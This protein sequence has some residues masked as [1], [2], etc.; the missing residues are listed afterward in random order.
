MYQRNDP[1]IYDASS[2]VL[3]A[4]AECVY[5]EDRFACGVVGACV[6]AGVEVPY[7]LIVPPG[8]EWGLGQVLA[9]LRGKEALGPTLGSVGVAVI[10]SSSRTARC[11]VEPHGSANAVTK[12]DAA[13]SH[14]KRRAADKQALDSGPGAAWQAGWSGLTNVQPLNLLF[15]G[16]SFTTPPLRQLSCRAATGLFFFLI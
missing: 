4:G 1:F 7:V 14:Q 16:S 8:P 12:F 3:S 13:S 9:D 10:V 2:H 15:P 6:A 11:V 5:L